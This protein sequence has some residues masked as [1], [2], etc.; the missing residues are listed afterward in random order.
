MAHQPFHSK[1][2]IKYIVFLF[3]FFCSV[4]FSQPSSDSLTLYKKEWENKS[5]DSLFTELNNLYR[6]AWHENTYRMEVLLSLMLEKSEQANNLERT[7]IIYHN[8]SV[9]LPHK[10]L[11]ERIVY[12]DKATQLIAD[13]KSIYPFSAQY[14]ESN[15]THYYRSGDYENAMKSYLK[16][17]E[18][19]EKLEDKRSQISIRNDIALV[20]SQTNNIE[21]ALDIHLENLEVVEN[22]PELNDDIR[23]LTN[24]IIGLAR[25]YPYLEDYE[26]GLKYCKRLVDLGEKTKHTNAQLFGMIGYANIYSL[27]SENQ[28]ALA[29]IDDIHKQFDEYLGI[30]LKGYLLL[31]KSR[32]L[33]NLGQYEEAIVHLM[34]IETLKDT[35]GLNY[36]GLQEMYVLLAKSFQEKGDLENAN[37]YFDQSLEV[38]EKNKKYRSALDREI[39]KRYDL[40]PFKKEI[41]DLSILA[42][43][44]KQRFK[45][46]LAGVLLLLILFPIIYFRQQRKNKRKFEALLIGIENEND[47]VHDNSHPKEKANNSTGVN[48]IEDDKVNELLNKL[49]VFIKKQYFLDPRCNLVWAAKK[50]GTNTTYL[51]KLINH[52]KQISFTKFITEKRINY[53]IEK[54][55]NDLQ[56]RSYTIEAIAKESGYNR[57]EPFSKAF[58][59]K[60]GIYPSYFIK[61]LKKRALD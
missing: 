26:N 33:Y 58:K 53:V 10:T 61:M 9:Y 4:G 36:I 32:A 12:S 16:A 25:I 15:G 59:R 2:L 44:N 1:K 23:L 21:D 31:Y 5:Y 45:I 7:I 27:T 34:E 48:E 60:T 35:Y 41:E 3:L 20:K 18:Y 46:A 42:Q 56:F 47:S 19:A 14:F 51:S 39:F 43:L 40:L 52:Q 54:L 29:L 30:N 13:S 24:V 28:K 55:Q 17:Y 49:D 11:K 22:T 6:T 37:M 8:F 38:F 57:A 50:M